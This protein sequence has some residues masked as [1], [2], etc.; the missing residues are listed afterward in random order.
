MTSR[1]NESIIFVGLHQ[2]LKK[3]KTMKT[4]ILATL[5][6]LTMIVG[7]FASCGLGGPKLLGKKTKSPSDVVNENYSSV[8]PSHTFLPSSA[9]EL[10]IT[11][12]QTLANASSNMLVFLD[13]SNADHPKYRFY[14]IDKGDYV[15]TLDALDIFDGEHF[16]INHLTYGIAYTYE[17]ES[18]TDDD[19]KYACDFY[20]FD[21]NK[22]L[23]ISDEEYDSVD[24]EEEDTFCILSTDTKAYVIRDFKILKEYNVGEFN[25]ANSY[26]FNEY[27]AIRR[28][29][30]GVA[31][32]NENLELVAKFEAPDNAYEFK[33]FILDGGNIF[34]TY[35]VEVE[36]NG[37]VLYD[38]IHYDVF[39][40]LFNVEKNKVKELSDDVVIKNVN[41]VS[42]L[43]A[44]KLV[45]S[46]YID[47]IKN[48]VTYY[49]IIDGVVSEFDETV[50]MTSEGKFT[51]RLSDFT[52]DQVSS[53]APL[54]KGLYIIDTKTGMKIV[55]D[56]LDV[57]L[58]L[59]TD[60]TPL[61][62]EYGFTFTYKNTFYVYDYNMVQQAK[63]EEDCY[64]IVAV[65]ASNIIYV[66]YDENDNDIY[67]CYRIDKNG[68]TELYNQDDENISVHPLG[69]MYCIEEKFYDEYMGYTHSKYTIYNGDGTLFDTITDARNLICH[70]G[71]TN[72]VLTYRDVK[73]NKRVYILCK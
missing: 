1:A 73:A 39:N 13:T 45:E 57:K 64:R 67:T 22:Y 38:G 68:V 26:S 58:S 25:N 41:S 31:V 70:S 29:T 72:C 53:I 63:L 7:I 66:K 35:V 2:K 12:D 5:L 14:N 8:K 47:E 23:T 6:L 11:S 10:S 18:S 9:T 21:G 30:K 65:S 15:L 24:I 71:E 34:V 54:G 40:G 56:Q 62:Y 46:P 4:K 20:D 27:Y 17:S 16:E 51:Y 60:I 43:T 33:Y 36:K 48:L 49:P 3:E 28:Y 37:D 50:A 69:D 19:V 44:N 42:N 55:N 59:D 32:Y 52:E 61:V